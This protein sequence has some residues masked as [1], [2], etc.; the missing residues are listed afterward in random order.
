MMKGDDVCVEVE[1]VVSMTSLRKR[2]LWDISLGPAHDVR[3]IL[4]HH[5]ITKARLLKSEP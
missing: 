4:N 3:S 5:Q 2:Q 1:V